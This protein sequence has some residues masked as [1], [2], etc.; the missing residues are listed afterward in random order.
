MISINAASA[1]ID[2]ISGQVR[3]DLKILPGALVPMLICNLTNKFNADPAKVGW[4]FNLDGHVKVGIG[5]GET[6]DR[7]HFGFVQY[8]RHTFFGIFYAGR[9]SREGSISMLLH[10]EIGTDYMLDCSPN[11]DK[12]FMWP[13]AGHFSQDGNEAIGN[14]GDH[15]VLSIRQS[16]P[17]VKTGHENY[18]FHIVDQRNAWAIFTVKDAAGKFQHLAHVP[19]DLRYE[20]KFKWVAGKPVAENLSTFTMGKVARG[21]PTDA[22]LSPVLASLSA[23]QTPIANDKIKAA[24]A[25]LLVPPATNR[26]DTDKWFMNVPRDFFQ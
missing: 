21:A 12:P 14:M 22:E 1:G 20:F 3:P 25:A 15:P 8:I 10:S 23:T 4:A 7:H 24:L 18:I 2:V 6:L 5:P 13:K 11:T 19:W 17:N 26:S 9:Q 16:Q